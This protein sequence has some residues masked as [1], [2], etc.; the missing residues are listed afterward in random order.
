MRILVTGGAG[1]I[2]SHTV[3]C[4][5]EGGD[6]VFVVDDLSSGHIVPPS[7]ARWLQADIFSDS[8]AAVWR[9]FKPQA[10]LHLAARVDVQSSWECPQADLRTNV[11]GTL[12]LLELSRT[13][14]NPKFVF[15]SS[16]AVYGMF[17]GQVSE[18]STL[19][20]SSPY[21]LG[22]Y[23]AERYISLWAGRWQI[24]WLILRYANVYGPY[25]PDENPKG[26]CRIFAQGLYNR[27][28]I[29]INGTG[30][31][32]RD[33]VSVYDVARANYLA[34]HSDLTA[35]TLNIATGKGHSILEV[36]NSLVEVSGRHPDFYFVEDGYVGVEKSILSPARAKV[37]LNWQTQWEFKDGLFDLWQQV[38]G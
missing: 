24:P 35:E 2:G 23:T 3:N 22:K 14:G 1:F 8:L 12:R 7:P 25:C 32:T 31:Q 5:L 11:E 26:V 21:G 19:F 17:F 15:A 16:A 38:A 9:D 20:P 18:I 10:V 30:S 29:M 34:C 28:P 36:F 37:L 4:L 6:E 27:S 13:Y 33:F